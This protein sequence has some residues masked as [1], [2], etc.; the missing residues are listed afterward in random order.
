MIPVEFEVDPC[1][2]VRIKHTNDGTEIWIQQGEEIVALNAAMDSPAS[3]VEALMAA[4]EAVQKYVEFERPD[5]TEFGF[6]RPNE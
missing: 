4:I 5:L 2:S 1:T 3:M 6:A